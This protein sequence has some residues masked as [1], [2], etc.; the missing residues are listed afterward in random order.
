MSSVLIIAR[1][2]DTVSQ[3]P[4]TFRH[5]VTCSHRLL[6]CSSV[7]LY[8]AMFRGL[9]VS[10]RLAYVYNVAPRNQSCVNL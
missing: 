7:N 4:D 3:R 1:G 8:F 5:I 2:V 10:L 9:I 6:G